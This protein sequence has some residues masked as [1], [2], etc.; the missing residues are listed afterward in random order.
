[1]TVLTAFYPSYEDSSVSRAGQN[2]APIKQG[3]WRKN[4]L[5]VSHIF[6]IPFV[7]VAKGAW[8]EMGT[9][10]W[11]FQILSPKARSLACILE[12]TNDAGES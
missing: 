5:L 2:P 3:T 4:I 6:R 12:P 9:F 11:H 10:E 8:M 1:M 7:L